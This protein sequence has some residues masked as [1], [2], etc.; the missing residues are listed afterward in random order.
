[1]GIPPHSSSSRRAQVDLAPV[2][3]TAPSL[4]GRFGDPEWLDRVDLPLEE[5]EAALGDLERLYRH[6]FGRH[7]LHGALLP[8][9]AA[10][11]RQLWLDL[12][13][14][15]GHV[16]SDLKA[17]AARQGASLRVISLDRRLRHL[18]LGRKRGHRQPAVVADATALPFR[19]GSLSCA[20]SHLF[21]HH[22][23]GS[24]NRRI[25]REMRRVAREVVV[26]DLRRCLVSRLLARLFLRL[27]RLGPTALHD[28]VVSVAR[29]Y[30]LGEITEALAGEGEAELVRR[31]PAHFSLHFAGFPPQLE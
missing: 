3:G 10:G 17:R 31:F 27:L 4:E 29:S 28:G 23:D 12:G 26:V 18:L 19:E 9:L 11:T 24:T 16:G 15:G 5:A 22:F 13:A 14:G 2:G 7:A 20:F 30:T 8:L 6:P 25:L 1:M 21:F